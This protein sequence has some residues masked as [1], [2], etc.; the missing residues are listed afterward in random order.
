MDDEIDLKE[1]LAVIVKRWRMIVLI[2]AVAALIGLYQGMSQ[3][4]LYRATA[5]VMPTD[6]GG[7]SLGS[8]LSLF[9]GFSGG[10]GS[11]GEGKLI[12][13]LKSRTLANEVAKSFDINII[14]PK[15][16]SDAKLSE[17]E[18]T[19]ALAGSLNGA[20][21]AKMGTSGLL[22]ITATWREPK[23][24]AEIANKYVEGL[25]RFLNLHALNINYQLIDP[26]I[27]TGDPFNKKI[28]LNAG[29]GLILGLF[30]GVFLAFFQ[31]YWERPSKQT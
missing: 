5:T 21:E 26:A 13:I 18:K 9:G 4:K 22:E 23:M 28:G 7:G 8:A 27:P 25:G 30:L 11:A 10:G 19:Q 6:S 31:E 17:A 2:G 24:A 1:Y 16:A 15:L 20:I 3:P 29:I 12:P 14:N